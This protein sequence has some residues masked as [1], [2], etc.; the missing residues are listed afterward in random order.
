ME[1]TVALH[2]RMFLHHQLVARR[3]TLRYVV[4]QR[5]LVCQERS[6]YIG[7]ELRLHMQREVKEPAV[8]WYRAMHSPLRQ[9]VSQQARTIAPNG[10]PGRRAVVGPDVIM[11]IFLVNPDTRGDSADPLQQCRQVHPQ[12]GIQNRTYELGNGRDPDG[13]C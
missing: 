11:T 6:P 3:Q 13:I 9:R 4:D 12:R 10:L 2:C 7:C 8:P 1:L 5:Q